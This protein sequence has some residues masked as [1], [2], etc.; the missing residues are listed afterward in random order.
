MKYDCKYCG[1]KA[2]SEYQLRKHMKHLHEKKQ[3]CPVCDKVFMNLKSHMQ[4]H[5]VTEK[6]LKCNLCNYATERSQSLKIHIE[7]VHEGVKKF[8]CE[9]C[10]LK[11]SRRITLEN[12]AI[13]V[14]GNGEKN[15]KCKS[16]GFGGS[17]KQN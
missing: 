2:S 6:K 9:V 1:S 5:S 8:S 11:F 4:I 10:L 7:S 15:W 3:T 12:H 16:C 13:S 17:E 14:H